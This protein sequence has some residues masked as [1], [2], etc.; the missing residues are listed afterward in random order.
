MVREKMKKREEREAKKFSK[1]KK[2]VKKCLPSLP[3]RNNDL[4]LE[5]CFYIKLFSAVNYN[6]TFYW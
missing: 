2:S 4:V 6:T 3:L 5:C 1:K